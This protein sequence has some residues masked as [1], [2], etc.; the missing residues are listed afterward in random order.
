MA[1]D[2]KSI[3][4]LMGNSGSG[5]IQVSARPAGEGLFPG[6]GDMNSSGQGAPKQGTPEWDEWYKKWLK[7][8]GQDGGTAT[9]GSPQPI[10]GGSWGN[11]GLPP[12]GGTW[13]NTGQSGMKRQEQFPGFGG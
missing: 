8:H 13:G 5:G 1:F 12:A 11:T 3:Q 7:E 6:L 10:A 9:A 2:M 4:A